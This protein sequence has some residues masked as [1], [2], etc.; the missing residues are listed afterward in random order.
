MT[1][2]LVATE[3]IH[4]TAAACDYLSPRL[5]PDDEVL[6][7]TVETAELEA[8]D[9]GDAANVARTRLVEPAVESVSREGKPATVIQE[10]AAAEG[11]DEI[12]L[13]QHHGDPDV[14]GEPPGSTVRA[15]LSDVSI[16]VVVVPI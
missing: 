5:G 9:A 13:G 10:I 4:T 7:L 6:L 15:V 11:V 14:A 8:R 16:P 12:L 3:S 2:V 1:R